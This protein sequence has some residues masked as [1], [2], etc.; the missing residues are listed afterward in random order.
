MCLKDPLILHWQW[1]EG[2]VNHYTGSWVNTESRYE[3]DTS[4]D[5]F[6]VDFVF[7]QHSTII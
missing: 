7:V 2:F 4:N 1:K 6:N 5:F 3:K